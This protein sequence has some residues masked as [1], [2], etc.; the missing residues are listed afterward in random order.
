[1]KI[2]T[3]SIGDELLCGEVVDTNASYIAGRLFD[4]GGRVFR[5]MTVGDDGGAIVAALTELAS[6]SDAVVVTGGLGP[7]ADD[8]TAEA[9]ARA[10]GTELE[11]SDAALEH[12]AQFS[13]RIPGGLH[14][15]NRR[16]ALLPKGCSLIPN[17]VGTACGFNVKL[18]GAEVFFLPGVPKEMKR[19]LDETVLPALVSDSSGGWGRITLKVFGISEAALGALLEGSLPAGSPVQI[20]YCVKFPEIHLILRAPAQHE[21]QLEQAAA[22]VRERVGEHLFAENEQSMDEIL[23]AL[24][25]KSGLTLALA[26]SCTGGMIA[27]RIT[28]QAGSSSYFLEGDVTY[29]NVAK[30]RML[31]VPAELIAAKGAVS[32]EVAC[33]MASGARRGTGTDLALSVTG[34]AG[35]DGGSAEKPVGTVYLALADAQTCRVERF[36]FHGDRETV[37]LITCF[38]ALDWLRRYLSSKAAPP[39]R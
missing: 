12:L 5:H 6:L 7:T 17:P 27:S 13:A 31:G 11:L 10:A 18:E 33:A 24:F 23:A 15:A 36:N 14:P 22:S 30:S 19:M 26:E 3:L 34:I 25:R 39:A 8:L 21:D 28:S 35:P 37:R 38:S 4:A 29:S 1:M 20:A 16:Q 2:S 32:A 9:A